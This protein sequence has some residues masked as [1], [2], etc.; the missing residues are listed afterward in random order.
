MNR[1]AYKQR[2]EN[3]ENLKLLLQVEKRLTV[4]AYTDNRASLF[5]KSET[6]RSFN[7]SFRLLKH[8]NCA[9]LQLIADA[10]NNE[11]KRVKTTGAIES[12]NR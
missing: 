6:E 10:V 1:P 12:N 7:L 2:V 3:F 4:T 8:G 11:V 5:V 9:T